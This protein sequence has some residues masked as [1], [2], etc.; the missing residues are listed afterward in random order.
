[1]TSYNHIPH[2]IDKEALKDLMEVHKLAVNAFHT[3][4]WYKHPSLLLFYKIFYFINLTPIYEK[5]KDNQETLSLFKSLIDFGLTFKKD[6]SQDTALQKECNSHV[7]FNYLY[8]IFSSY[9]LIIQGLLND[10]N[11]FSILSISI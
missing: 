1:M 3:A 5:N 11:L 10:S 4:Y 8:N 2:S 7:A 6:L 9:K